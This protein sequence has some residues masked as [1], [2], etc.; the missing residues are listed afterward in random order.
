MSRDKQPESECET[1][2]ETYRP[3][4]VNLVN[5][6]KQSR[7]QLLEGFDSRRELL[8]WLQRLTV[9]TLGQIEQDFYRSF[10]HALHPRDGGEMALLAVVLTEDARTRDIPEER[11]ERAR[12]MLAAKYIM[13]AMHRAY[14]HLRKDAGEYIADGRDSEH[15]PVK[16]SYI[17]MR[18]AFDEIES[19]QREALTRLLDGLDEKRE[20]MDWGDVVEQATHGELPE[21]D[22]ISRCYLERS[23]SR[24]LTREST[25]EV[26]RAR[27]LFAAR[28]LIPAFNLGVRDLAGRAGELP[29]EEKE[30]SKPT[31]A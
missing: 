25:P 14:K 10:A 19:D 3:A 28:H 5:E 7:E 30:D 13:P 26:R 4:L 23:T 11:V 17:A 15:D 8:E 31:E 16:Q 24:L 12:E 18:P 22:F 20:I 1:E 6:L 27:E 9:R 29:S 2:R 21:E